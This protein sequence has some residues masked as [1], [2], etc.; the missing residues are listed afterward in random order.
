MD[1]NSLEQLANKINARTD[2]TP[3]QKKILFRETAKKLSTQNNETVQPQQEMSA[4]PMAPAQE[5]KTLPASAFGRK[6]IQVGVDSR[7]IIDKLIDRASDFGNAVVSPVKNAVKEVG[8]I[9]E[10]DQSPVSKVL[11][12]AASAASAPFESALAPVMEAAKAPFEFI[13]AISPDSVN[14]MRAEEIDKFKNI[15][16]SVKD[17]I[18]NTDTAQTLM[19]KFKSLPEETQKNLIAGTELA[20]ILIPYAGKAMRTGVTGVLTKDSLT[21]AIGNTVKNIVKGPDTPKAPAI[22]QTV[23]KIPDDVKSE[24]IS[25]FNTAIKPSKAGKQNITDVFKY[26]DDAINAMKR[27]ADNKKILEYV[28]ESGNVISSGKLPEGL[29]ETA[30]ANNII[31]QKTYKTYTDLKGNVVLDVDGEVPK[32]MNEIADKHY[33]TGTNTANIAKKVADEWAMV[34]NIT[35]EK[36]QNIIEVKNSHLN[37]Y[38]SGKAGST[39]AQAEIDAQIVKYLRDKLD[40]QLLSET[41]LSY[42]QLRND[43]KAALTIEKDLASAVLRESSRKG[44]GLLKLTDIL[45]GGDITAGII[46]GNPSL[47]VKGLAGKGIKEYINFLNDPN[48]IIKNAFEKLGRVKPTGKTLT[49]LGDEVA[50]INAKRTADTITNK[51]LARKQF[52]GI[53]A[54]K[55]PN[56]KIVGEGFTATRPK[57]VIA[58]RKPISRINKEVPK[59]IELSLPTEIS[60]KKTVNPEVVKS[61]SNPVVYKTSLDGVKKQYRLNDFADKDGYIYHTTSPDNVDSIRETGLIPSHGYQGKAV[62]FAPD[63]A[64]TIG[65]ATSDG[66]IVRVNV[67]KLDPNKIISGDVSGFGDPTELVYS[68]VIPPSAVEF[69][70]KNGWVA[71]ND[72][73]IRPNTSVVR[74][75]ID[76]N[77]AKKD[78]VMAAPIKKQDIKAGEFTGKQIAKEA[79]ALGSD[80]GGISDY[81]LDSIKKEN[82]KIETININELRKLDE[83]LDAYLKSGYIRDFEGEPFAMDPIVSSKGEVYDGYN[84]IAQAIENGD[85]EI[86]I[87]RGIGKPDIKVADVKVQAPIINERKPIDRVASKVEGKTALGEK[88]IQTGEQKPTIKLKRDVKVTTI[89]GEKVTIPEDEVLKAYESG[90]KALL[91]DG[92]EYIVSKSQY[93]NIKNNSL[94]SEVKEFAPE[95]K[96]TE[97]FIKMKQDPKFSVT[98]KSGTVKFYGTEEQAKEFLAK[99]KNPEWVIAKENWPS[100]KDVKYQNYQLPGGKNYKEI[101]IKANTTLE[102]ELTRTGYKFYEDTGGSW[103]AE[104]PDG[105]KV[106]GYKT[107]M[108]AMQSFKRDAKIF[109]SSHWKEPNVISHLRLNERKYN[110]KKVTF[111]EELQS[112]WAREVRKGSANPE[113]QKAFDDYSKLLKDKYNTTNPTLKATPEEITKYNQLLSK[114]SGVVGNPL[115]KNWQELS[116]KRALKEAVDNGSEYFAWINGEQTATRYGLAD[117]L[118]NIAWKL[119]GDLTHVNLETKKMGKVDIFVNKDGIIKNSGVNSFA[120]KN[121]A[122]VVPKEISKKILTEPSGDLA[123]E[124]LNIGGEWAKNLYDKQ[125]KNIVEKLTGSKVEILDMQLADKSRTR[126][127]SIDEHRGQNLM[128]SELTNSQIKVGKKIRNE[129]GEPYIITDIIGDGKFEAVKKD[130]ISGLRTDSAEYRNLVARWGKE[131]DISVK[132]SAGQQ[133]IK[134][135]PEIRAM[136]NGENIDLVTS[137]DIVENFHKS[138]RPVADKYGLSVYTPEEYK[139]MKVGLSADKKVGYAVKPDGD[140]ISVFNKGEKGRGQEAV[141]DA[142]NNGGTK[143]DCFEQLKGYY[144][145]FGFE[146]TERVKWDDKYAPKNWDYTKGGRPDIIYMNLNNKKYAEYIKGRKGQG[147]G[148]STEV[149][150]RSVES[151]GGRNSR[152][153]K[154]TQIGSGR[155]PIDRLSNK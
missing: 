68:E 71:I 92:R 5:N 115:L 78:V 3:E 9:I 82:Y 50:N 80:Q 4:Q 118:D 49:A 102:K 95:L 42:Q 106:G 129:S 153:D 86:K 10:S 145:K 99:S 17:N 29:V 107:K 19:A 120:G 109:N 30:Q 113:A 25:A 65:Q 88:I 76:R 52:L 57:D 81:S 59:N 124:G 16:S 110:G 89:S 119:D 117:E 54:N 48:R 73:N 130:V 40:N 75:S 34:K 32:L 38:F 91:K 44:N 1:K 105:T 123:G 41:D 51:E 100:T 12:S 24:I 144:E 111:M 133:G 43:Y 27:I 112:D 103:I 67:K 63:E 125:V 8:D 70:T 58:T 33:L 136:V 155:K 141:I 146:E 2:L 6:P 11:Q 56:N 101:L 127:Y 28:D 152:V 77:A 84:R 149:F 140:I 94:K 97:D 21:S 93:E 134:I 60:K 36:A 83:D 142:I 46:G 61:E 20:A 14:E 138:L 37:S 98:T 64:S 13:K 87:L 35:A 126:F 22:V 128:G 132:K 137:T 90:G 114:G 45:T 7:S 62:Y 104:K 55:N 66:A 148:G 108:E 150:N 53:E 96:E 74:K 85:T 18:L 23:A 131:F 72:N 79:K 39:Q 147:L 31:K 139:K 122:D 151:N 26:N 116:V 69:K 143:L 135:T 47:L 15:L 154:E 121:I